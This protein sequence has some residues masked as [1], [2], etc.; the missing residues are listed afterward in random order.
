MLIKIDTE[1]NMK[2][3]TGKDITGIGR[4]GIVRHMVRDSKKEGTM[5]KALEKAKG[6]KFKNKDFK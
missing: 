6:S 2:Y 3:G 1:N 5:N 4:K